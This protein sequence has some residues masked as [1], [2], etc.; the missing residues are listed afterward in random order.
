MGSPD[1]MKKTLLLI[2]LLALIV[3]GCSTTPTAFDRSFGNITTNY[4]EKIV[5][6]TNVVPLFVTNP[7]VEIHYKTNEVGVPTPFFITNTFTIVTYQ[8]NLTAGT[9]SVPVITVTPNDTSKAIASTAGTVVGTFLP[10]TGALVTEGLLGLLTI[11]FGVRSRQMSGQ[12]DVLS[13]A[14]GTLTQIIETG[15]QIM[16]TTPQGQQAANAFTAWMVS[17]QRETQTI[18]AISDL[19]TKVV[20][21]DEAKKAAEAILRLIQT[22]PTK[23]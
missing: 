6:L 9:N 12:K 23:T 5:I 18:A 17:H 14:A 7:I 20:D 22:P 21:K 15:R 11:F 19:V 2:P 13:Q 8:T 16:A 10:G 3:A 1:F 4:V